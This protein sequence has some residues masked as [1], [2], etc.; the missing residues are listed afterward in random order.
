MKNLL[1]TSYL[2]VN[3]R[4]VLLKIKKNVYTFIQ[5]RTTDPTLHSYTR[6]KLKIKARLKRKNQNNVVPR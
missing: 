5:H 3:V 4:S 6:K 2:M 1:Q